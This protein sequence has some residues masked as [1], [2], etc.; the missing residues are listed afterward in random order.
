MT[1]YPD[2]SPYQYLND[3]KDSSLNIGWLDGSN[4]YL[5]GDT[6]DEFQERL[7]EFCLNKFSFYRTRGFHVCNLKNCPYSESSL[8]ENEEGMVRLG[9]AEIRVIGTNVIYASPNLIYHYVIF[10]KYRPPN[11]FL[12][13]VI[14]SPSP[15]SESYN[16]LRMRLD[17]P[18]ME[19]NK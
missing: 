11:E 16:N 8:E 1:Y 17:P 15:A 14:K 5:V 4:P 12:E 13:A 3:H 18:L 19:A 6:S 7:K 10:H 2:F 9:S